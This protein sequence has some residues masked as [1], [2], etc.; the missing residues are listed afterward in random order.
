MAT[1][2]TEGEI[3]VGPGHQVNDI[4]PVELTQRAEPTKPQWDERDRD[5]LPRTRG[6][7][8]GWIVAASQ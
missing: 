2:P 3:R 8:R 1:P 7:P 4:Y 6:T 5:T